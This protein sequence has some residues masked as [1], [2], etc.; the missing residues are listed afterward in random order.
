MKRLNISGQLITL[1]VLVMLIGSILFSVV[2]MTTVY[3][4]AENEV[5]SR[6]TT[7]SN[8][9]NSDFGP[10]DKKSEP[11][12]FPDMKLG[13]RISRNGEIIESNNLET[14]YIKSSEL[15]LLISQ[16]I[17]T[18]ENEFHLRDYRAPG[19]ITTSIK[20]VYYVFQMRDNNYTILFTDTNYVNGLITNVS[21]RLILIFFGL[22]L[23]SGISIYI[24]NYT[25]ARR[26]HRLQDH[27]INLPK[28]KY[29]ESYVDESLDEIGQLSRSV[30]SMRL[31]I[32][33]NEHTKQDM[34]QNLSHDFKTP[35][36]V[37]KSYAEA[38]QDGVESKEQLSII[39]EQADIL[40][41]KVNRL[42][43]YNSLEYLEKDREFDDIDMK[44]LINEVVITYKYQTNIEFVLDLEDN[45]TFKGY[46]E[47]WS[48][49]ISNII[50]NAKR[51]AKTQ[52][53]IVLKEDLLR[54]YNDGDH[55]DEQF[56]NNS[57][58]P[59]EKGSK[60]QFGL[61]MSIVQKTVN[62]F[63]MNLSVRNEDPIGVSFI[64]KK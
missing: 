17:S 3:G 36:A 59:Y 54:I 27:I 48:T 64:I 37:I 38:I 57:F 1:F 62:F 49:V 4:V 43:Q 2:T 9:L 12:S 28:N 5:Y 11:G 58:K 10:Q 51:Y 63:N 35:I 6:L 13:F 53:K 46:R 25:F 41:N 26:I 52:I 32:G 44:E 15:D 61:G 23:I 34:L 14:D 42:L 40:R 55:I 21:L 47:N 19:K 7:Y 22:L 30:E 56:V 24:W 16:I 31:E 45:I 20:T 8:M 29:E 39:I 60:G 18:N 33:K 50:D